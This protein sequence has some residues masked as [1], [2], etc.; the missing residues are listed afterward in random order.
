MLTDVATNQSDRRS[1]VLC[2]TLRVVA[3]GMTPGTGLTVGHDAMLHL[4][5]SLLDGVA[6][7]PPTTLFQLL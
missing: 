4:S 2:G 7:S 1:A 3:Y 5:V 6:D